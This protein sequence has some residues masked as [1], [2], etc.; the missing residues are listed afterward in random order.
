MRRTERWST[1]AYLKSNPVRG[2]LKDR[3]TPKFLIVSGLGLLMWIIIAGL[4]FISG[5]SVILK[6]TVFPTLQ[7]DHTL[8]GEAIQ[9]VTFHVPEHHV[10]LLV[11]PIKW[12]VIE[13]IT[14]RNEWATR[15]AVC[16]AIY[17][18]LAQKWEWNPHETRFTVYA[19]PENKRVVLLEGT[20]LDCTI[21]EGASI[22]PGLKA[23]VRTTIPGDPRG[24]HHV[25]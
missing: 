8:L 3:L 2:W 5:C 17:D 15:R 23:P 16:F 7:A 24:G 9:S 10:Y 25:Y 11:E 14:K 6:P 13:K 12:A 19:L 18:H 20:V 4:L 22:W 1:L 21:T